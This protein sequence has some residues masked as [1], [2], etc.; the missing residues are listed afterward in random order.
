MQMNRV[1]ANAS[2]RA[3]RFYNILS[4]KLVDGALYWIK[5]DFIGWNESKQVISFDV[6]KEVF[7]PVS[8]PS[9]VDLNSETNRYSFGDLKQC[10][11]LSYILLTIVSRYGK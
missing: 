5:D 9:G 10:L 2:R 11:C 8:S 1:D 3:I 4:T 6:G 7:C